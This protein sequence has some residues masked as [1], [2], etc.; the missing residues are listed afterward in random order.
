MQ[1]NF[2]IRRSIWKSLSLFGHSL[3]LLITRLSCSFSLSLPHTMARQISQPTNQVQS[4]CLESS[5]VDTS[6]PIGETIFC[7]L[8]SF[9]LFWDVL[10]PV[11][12]HLLRKYVL[13]LV[14]PR[15]GRTSFT[16]I[17]K[18]K[19]WYFII[20]PN[21]CARHPLPKHRT[22]SISTRADVMCIGSTLSHTTHPSAPHLH[23][24]FKETKAITS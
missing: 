17:I 2:G 16:T 19:R 9:V 23:K 4:D 13:V 5:C 3:A 22:I 14:S 20:R 12:A 8:W 1:L 7:T 11:P 15:Y 6:G 24:V 10:L 21:V 18:L